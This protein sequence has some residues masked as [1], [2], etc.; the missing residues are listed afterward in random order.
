MRDLNY[1]LKGLCNRFREGSFATQ[2]ARWRCLALA[3][4]HLH[5]LGFRH[6]SANGLKPKHIDAL[7]AFWKQLSISAGTIKNRMSHLRWWADKIGKSG[8]IPALNSQLDIP[9]RSYVSHNSKAIV[10]SQ[11][12]LDLISDPFVKCSLLLQAAFG[13][14][15][16]ESIKFIPSWADKGNSIHLKGSWCKGGQARIV[17]ITN[18]NQRIVLDLAHSLVGKASL[19]PSHRSYFQHLKVYEAQTSRAGLHNLH[20]LRHHYA[21]QR[22]FQL[23]GSLS[24]SA[25][26]SLALDES[27]DESHDNSLDPTN[28]D[29]LD[30]ASLDLDDNSSGIDT[31]SN[32]LL[33][34]DNTNSSN[35]SNGNH[36]NADSVNSFSIN[37]LDPIHPSDLSFNGSSNKL[38]AEQKELHRQA[39]LTISKELG[40]HRLQVTS[41]YLGKP[42]SHAPTKPL[43]K[44]LT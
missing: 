41:V 25:L 31:F 27:H 12:S 7:I 26:N 28:L 4:D 15:R 23:T 34:P 38:S 6:L 43:V 24:S 1:Q 39:R 2:A 21:Q 29:S 11:D 30:S 16:E 19:I 32:T 20:G 14:R 17:P 9:A 36:N 3:A 13:L 33:S 44:N 5:D 40:H 22:F 18:P 37:V 35:T 8:M 42:L 10:L